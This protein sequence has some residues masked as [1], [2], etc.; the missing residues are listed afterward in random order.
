M[1]HSRCTHPEKR[2]PG[3]RY[4]NACHAAYMRER[5]IAQRRELLAL[6]RRVSQLAS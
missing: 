2:K 4:C 5:R 1:K 3:R 6:L